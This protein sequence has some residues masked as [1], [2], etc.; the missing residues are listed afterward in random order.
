VVTIT[1]ARDD[2]QACPARTKCT[3]GPSKSRQ[4]RVRGQAY[5]EALQVARQR[6][7]TSA[8]RKAYAARAGIEGTISQ[9]VRRC[10]LR[11]ARYIGLAKT[12]LQQVLIATAL[13]L[14][15]VV[16]WQDEKPRVRTRTSAFKSLALA[17]S[18]C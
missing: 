1:F 4:L 10:D 16:A 18:V 2:C 5:H 9:G 7:T 15:R 17:A 13:N 3:R 11:H 6:Q 14:L 12:H 8:Y